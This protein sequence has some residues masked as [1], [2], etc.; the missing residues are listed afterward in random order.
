M[1][2]IKRIA[3]YLMIVFILTFVI[4][5]PAGRAEEGLPDLKVVNTSLS[6]QNTLHVF[7]NVLD[8]NNQQIAISYDDLDITIK[9]NKDEVLE[10]YTKGLGNYN[11]YGTTYVLAVDTSRSNTKHKKMVV[12]MNVLISNMQKADKACIITFGDDVTVLQEF[13][14]DKELLKSV[15]NSIKY[16]DIHTKLYSGISTAITYTATH[17]ATLPSKKALILYS[18]GFNDD[19]GGEVS[20]DS[21][22][23]RIDNKPRSLPIYGLQFDTRGNAEKKQNINEL[24]KII[25]ASKGEFVPL[26]GNSVFD[27]YNEIVD[28]IDSLYYLDLK[29]TAKAGKYTI[30]IKTNYHSV[31]LEDSFNFATNRDIQ[32]DKFEAVAEEPSTSPTVSVD[33]KSSTT[34]ADTTAHIVIEPLVIVIACVVFICILIIF[35]IIRLVKHKKRTTVSIGQQKG[36]SIYLKPFK[37]DDYEG[38]SVHVNQQVVIGS[39]KSKCDVVYKASLVKPQHFV[40][41]YKNDHLFIFNV[42]MDNET[43]VNGFM[44]DS[45]RELRNNDIIAFGSVEIEIIF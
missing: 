2:N 40:L 38:V 20:A 30:T 45:K 44:L 36:K 7:F 43:F 31:S 15:V 35:I 9:N 18:D 27:C 39:N 25:D 10:F 33:S 42:H 12:S 1:I 22:I 26:A 13:T 6:N 14:N 37:T 8:Q 29:T 11:N 3:S 4:Y 21:L 28:F 17:S 16:N 23:N 41:E 34:S 32:T 24:R 19:D 5:I